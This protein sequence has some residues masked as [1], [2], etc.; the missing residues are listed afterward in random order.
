MGLIK[1]PDCGKDIS[2]SAESCP[3]CGKPMFNGIRCPN[4]KSNNVIKIS[5]ASKVGSFFMWGIFAA[6]KI[7]KT[8]ECK[9]CGYRW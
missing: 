8:Y 3:N 6:G 1:C 2:T 7:T 5:G 4:C 9:N